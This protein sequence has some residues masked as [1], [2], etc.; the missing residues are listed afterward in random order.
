LDSELHYRSELMYATF[1]T[2]R[3]Q[4]KTK[5]IFA[6]NFCGKCSSTYELP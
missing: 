4:C 6:C 1:H 3:C 2:Q 5:F